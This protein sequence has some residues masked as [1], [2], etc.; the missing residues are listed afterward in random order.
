MDDKGKSPFEEWFNHLN[1]QAAAKITTSLYRLEQGN[2]SNAKGVGEG[3]FE[4]KVDFGPGYRIYFGYKDNTIIILLGGGTKQR[5][6]ND[7]KQ[8]KERRKYYK[9]CTTH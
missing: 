9:K 8:A 6:Q 2:T 7:I 1:T 5:Q 3:V 4:L